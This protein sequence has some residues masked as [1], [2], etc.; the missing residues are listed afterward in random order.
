MEKVNGKQKE[1]SMVLDLSDFVQEVDRFSRLIEPF[2]LVFY[3]IDDIR[4]WRFRK[5]TILMWILCNI[6]CIWITQGVV[7]LL[8]SCIVIAIATLAL[9]Q[10]HIHIL[11]RVLP[12]TKKCPP[13]TQSDGVLDTVQNF[14]YSLIEMHDFIVKSNEYL[15]YFYSILKWDSVLPS[16][17]YHV[18]VCVFLLSIVIC[19]ARWNCFLLI[20]WFFLCHPPMLKKGFIF[21]REQIS[22]QPPTALH[23]NGTAEAKNKESLSSE[24]KE[25][26]MDQCDSNEGDD[27]DDDSDDEVDID[28]VGEDSMISLDP[29]PDKPGMVAR[30]MEI[31]KRRKQ[32]ANESC[33]DCNASFASIL[34]KRLY[35]RHCGFSFCNKCCYQKVPRSVFGATSPAAVTE[36]VLVCCSC[37]AVLVSRGD[38]KSEESAGQGP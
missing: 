23:E 33:Q 11:S 12:S 16:A 35:C 28:T 34:V 36:T 22:P 30:L 1:T 10:V 19:P 14:R 20:N 2:A 29:S 37:H 6:A 17:I 7:F 32:I 9:F 4:R 5:A 13:K 38:V 21:I 3:L 24:P 25:K 31:K 15:S 27:E 26:E 8:A 18:Q